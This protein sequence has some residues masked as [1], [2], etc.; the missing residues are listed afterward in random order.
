MQRA[1]PS[2][3]VPRTRASVVAR[4]RVLDW[5]RAAH[6]W[7][8]LWGAMLGLMFGV[9]GLLMNHR[10]VLRIPV[11]ESETTH[12]VVRIPSPF[13]TPD[14]LT[15]WVRGRFSLPNARAI[16]R[17][18]EPAHVRFSGQEFDQ[19]ERWSV[20]LATSK[21][22]VNARHVP[23]SGVVDLEAQDA[24]GWSLLM[25]LHTGNGASAA[26][27]VLVDTIAGAFIVLTLTGILLWT[28]LRGPRLAGAAVLL[29][30]PAFTAAY[31]A[32]L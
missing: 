11:H 9:T 24:T 12:T 5:I 22:S 8:G 31:L 2:R 4:D 13:E 10:A 28:R 18:E 23:G 16:A 6:L 21:V 15:T 29:A 27:V 32:T 3:F 17:R 30:A 26:W 20:T 25:R 7:I 14:Q 1:F 19:L